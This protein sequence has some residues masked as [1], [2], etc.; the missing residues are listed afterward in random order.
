[1]LTI[2]ILIGV[3]TNYLKFDLRSAPEAKQDESNFVR[4]NVAFS[5]T[6]SE[7]SLPNVATIKSSSY[8]QN[9]KVCFRYGMM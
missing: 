8:D 2:Y 7:I 9:F 4:K 3:S 5:P 6:D 1:V